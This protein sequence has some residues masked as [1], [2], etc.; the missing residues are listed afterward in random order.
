MTTVAL[1]RAGTGKLLNG[2]RLVAAV[3]VDVKA[4]MM[5]GRNRVLYS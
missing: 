4:Q 5:A 2:V 3:S 1:L